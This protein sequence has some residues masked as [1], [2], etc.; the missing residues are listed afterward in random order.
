[1][2]LIAT[3]KGGDFEKPPV[4]VFP[5]VCVQVIDLGTQKNEYEGKITT[6]HQV[7]IGWELCGADKLGSGASHLMADGKPFLV[8]EIYTLSLGEMANLRAILEGWRGRPFTEEEMEGFDISALLGKACL[9]DIIHK[10]KK[11]GSLKAKVSSVKRWPSDMEAPNS[12]NP[13]VMFD[14][15]NFDAGVYNGLSDWLQEKIALSPEYAAAVG[16]AIAND[17]AKDAPFDD[18]IPF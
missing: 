5:A 1:M 16:R 11:N 6:P 4:G 13:H 17:P 14:L 15:T 2:A 18:E 9:V 7:R 3:S 10:A 12:V 8:T